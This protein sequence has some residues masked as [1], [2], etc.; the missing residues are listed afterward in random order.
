MPSKLLIFELVLL[1]VVVIATVYNEVH[2]KDKFA[3]K[4]SYVVVPICALMTLGV[5]IYDMKHKSKV[6]PLVVKDVKPTME[7]KPEVA[8]VVMPVKI[9]TAYNDIVKK[10]VLF[11]DE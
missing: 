11:D 1:I 9:D 7:P 3:A 4:I 8:N 6:V 2:L 5:A 10:D